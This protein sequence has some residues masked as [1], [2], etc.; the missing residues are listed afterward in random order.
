MTYSRL[1]IDVETRSAFDLRKGGAAAYARDPTTDCLVAC[2]A[3]DDEEPRTWVRGEAVDPDL[4]AY[5]AGD[6]PI[7]AF[8]AM[9]EKAIWDQILGPR[10]GWPVPALERYHCTAAMSAAMALPRTLAQVAVALGLP[11]QKDDAGKRVMMQLARPRSKPG[12]PIRFWEP[13]DTPAKFDTLYKYCAQD[14]IVERAI[15]KRLRPLS[16]TEREIWLE[17]CRINERGLLIDQRAIKDALHIVAQATDTLNAELARLTN[18][19]VEKVSKV[20]DLTA[21]LQ[22]QGVDVESLDKAST[23]AALEGDLSPTVRRVLEIRQEGAKSST[24]KL[25]S[26]V[27]AACA[28]GR[29]RG[30]MRY[31]GASTGRDAGELVQPQNF[32]RPTLKPR[33]VEAAI[34]MLRLRNP[35]LLEIY[36][37]PLS[38]VASCLRAMIVAAPGH[39]IVAGDLSNIEGRVAAWLAG[40]EWKLQ[41]FREYDAGTGPDLYKVAAGGIFGINPDDVD[42]ERR[43]VG[44]VSELS[45]QFQGGHGAYITMGANYGIKPD[46]VAQVV[47]ASTD[48]DIWEATAEGYDPKNRYELTCDEWTGIRIVVDGWRRKH[49]RLVQ[50][51]ADTEEAA[52]AALAYPGK[53]FAVGMTAYAYK[54]GIL[55]CRLPNGRL[56][57]YVDAKMAEIETPWGAKKL[58]VTYMSLNS[59]TKRY[60]RTKSYGGLLFQ[61]AVQ[62]VARDVIM[63]AKLRFVKRGWPIILKVHDELVCELPKGLVTPAEFVA[64][65]SV[66]PAW[67]T[68]LPVSAKASAGR[69][70][71]KD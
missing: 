52:V 62:A 3:F 66:L 14:V 59:M 18:Y 23:K 54:D 36:G 41:A 10:Y 20:A 7:Y 9:F 68:G 34:D 6:G 17:N 53:S 33:D 61:N 55:W 67:A 56:L 45:A 60:E 58:A 70:Y 25:K 8:N 5:L 46:D 50:M 15:S 32:P 35:S 51:W 43:Q 1:S 39:E 16:A 24:A 12:M 4:I 19:R 38:V 71:G 2:Y 69:R 11:E 28:D 49:P 65:M 64:E 21:W 44:K 47:K 30:T 37:Q 27:T 63:E 13:E 48:S 29:I 31:H 26:F 40:E 57:A 22:E 42:D